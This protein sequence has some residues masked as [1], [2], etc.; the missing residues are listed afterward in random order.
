MIQWR[1]LV[2]DMLEDSPF[3]WLL[4]SRRRWVLWAV[5]VLLLAGVGA[6]VG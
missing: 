5:S 3:R 2:Q 6:A 1:S 4:F